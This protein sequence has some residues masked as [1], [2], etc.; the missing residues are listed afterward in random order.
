MKEYY[1]VISDILD[2]LF[3]EDTSLSKLI[4]RLFKRLSLSFDIDGI[5]LY[6]L[7]L[8]DEKNI[9]VPFIKCEKEGITPRDMKDLPSY[10]TSIDQPFIGNVEKIKDERLKT[11]LMEKDIKH[12]LLMPIY[13]KRK[14]LG[15]ILISKRGD[16]YTEEDIYFL[17]AILKIFEVFLVT[18]KGIGDLS[19]LI[20]RF[21]STLNSIPDI[22]IIKDKK[23]KWVFANRS[24]LEFYGL[25]D[26]EYKGK[27]NEEL[28]NYLKDEHFKEIF[29]KAISDDKIIRK[30]GVPLRHMSKYYLPSRGDISFDVRKIPIYDNKKRFIGI[31]S[32]AKDI[33]E[34]EKIKRYIEKKERLE[35]LGLMAGSIAHD[36]N[37]LLTAVIGNLSVLELK[38]PEELKKYI[39]NIMDASLRARTLTKQMLTYVS[40]RESKREI[41][42]LGEEIK[43]METL[44]RSVVSKNVKI[45]I[46]QMDSGLYIDGA[47]EQ[48]QQILVNLLVNASDAIGDREGE[49]KIAV[50]KESMDK[51]KFSSLSLLF[52]I[53]DLIYAVIDVKDNGPGIP[54]NI[55]EHI[56]EPFFTT[57]KKGRGLGLFSIYSIVKSYKGAIELCDEKVGTRFKI[58]FPLSNKKVTE[59]EKENEENIINKID[60]KKSS[61]KILV[62]DDEEYILDILNQML[63]LLGHRVTLSSSGREALKLLSDSNNFDIVILDYTM[64]GITGEKLLHKIKKISPRTKV[65]FS[66]GYAKEDLADIIENENILF[67]HKP[68]TLSNLKKILS[69][70]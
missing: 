70:I 11:Y 63:S 27:T 31:L 30:N 50:Y 32:I 48:I 37:N 62:V 25:T 2:Y 56:F 28:I 60:D 54:A 34:D 1:S 14:Y 49:V 44:F 15:F 65:V 4:T 18:H 40:Y 66:S 67:L 52:P 29:I 43:N 55:K 23:G 46:S 68:Y 64:P 10:Y 57:K 69:E 38:I 22:I 61:Y 16:P 3:L 41:F 13:T 35:S 21:E 53:E 58:Y 47:R 6:R 9:Y 5:Y 7:K 8:L 39:N 45:K 33:T 26:I 20:F 24:A 17:R 36:F 12:V 42:D 51:E 59:K 19:D